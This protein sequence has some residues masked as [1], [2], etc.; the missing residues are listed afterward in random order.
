[1]KHRTMSVAI[2]A[3]VAATA[4]S[5]IVALPEATASAPAVTKVLTFMEEN[6]S[7]SEMQTQ[8]PY[9]NG[10]SKQYAYANH[11]RGI[12]YPSEPNY[13]AIAGGST[14]GDTA[15]HNPAYQ[16]AGASMFGQTTSSASYVEGMTSNC[17][18]ASDR[19]NLYAVK[20][21]PWASFT[22]ER[23]TCN[24][25]DVP[26]SRLLSDVRA[27]T[28]PSVG[29]VI[30]NMCHDAHDC[31]PGAADNWLKMYLPAIMAGPDFT[32]GRLAVVVTADTDDRS[33]GNVVLTTVLQK[34]LNGTHKVVGTALNHYSL[35]RLYGQADCRPP[36][37][38]AAAAANMAAAFGLPT[39]C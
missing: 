25:R 2:A 29:M 23:T 8:M 3:C 6:H 12:T 35:T 10:L 16:V 32:S 4:L 14:F 13:L 5:G 31:P 33:A 30:P 39:P 21:N 37:R 11:Y 38:S 17:Q 34:N 18:Q 36:L 27:G 20:H 15:D 28:L 26:V 7:L 1:M 24:A 19:S 22:D 9:L